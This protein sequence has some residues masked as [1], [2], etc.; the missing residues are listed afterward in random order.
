MAI[1]IAPFYNVQ[2][3]VGPGQSNSRSDVLLV[4]Y[5]LFNICVNRSGP[6]SG[7]HDLL[8][9]SILIPE[10]PNGRGADGIFPYD[11]R[12]TPR[13]SEW[14]SA[15]QWTCNQRG[16]G[17]LTVDGKINRAKVGWGKPGAPSGGW[18]T[19]QAMNRV[20]MTINPDSFSRLPTLGD[21]P[22]DLR[23]DL[24]RFQFSH[25]DGPERL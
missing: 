25:Y 3:A 18:Y 20:L 8:G 19:I 2:Y 13:T 23:A 11:G 24:G 17:M 6:W 15:F 12:W 21:L 5:M 14:I 22:G 10:S 7:G 16:L 9:G 1:T 4:Q